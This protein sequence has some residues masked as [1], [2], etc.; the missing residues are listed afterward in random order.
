MN[1]FLAYLLVK[2]APDIDEK[3][4]SIFENPEMWSQSKNKNDNNDE[5]RIIYT[6]HLEWIPWNW[7]RV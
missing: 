5:C 7:I 1:V 2:N 6:I 4:I 3:S